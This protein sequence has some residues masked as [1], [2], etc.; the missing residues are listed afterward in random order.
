MTMATIYNHLYVSD[1]IELCAE[2]NEAVI[3]EDGKIA[4]VIEIEEV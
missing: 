4:A 3:V 1:I 2:H